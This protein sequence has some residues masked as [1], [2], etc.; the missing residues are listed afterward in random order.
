MEIATALQDRF[1]EPIDWQKSTEAQ[2]KMLR[3]AVAQEAVRAVG[4]HPEAKGWYDENIK[5]TVD[6]LK[7]LDPDIARPENDFIFKILLAATSDGNKVRPQFLQSWDE[8]TNWKNTGKISGQFVS[9]D[10]VSN[11]RK[12]L[13]K[14]EAMIQTVGWEKARDFL[15]KKGT[16]SEIREALVKEFGFTKQDAAK[17]G[18]SELADEV[19]PYAIVLG[20]KLGSFFNNL[21]GDFSSVTMDRWFMRTMGR[22]TGT[23]VDTSAFKKVRSLRAALRESISKMTPS[24]KEFLKISSDKIK[25]DNIDA[26]AKSISTRFSKKETR[27]RAAQLESEGRPFMEEV[28][29]RSNALKKI[30]SPLVEAPVN[31]RHRR[32]IRQRIAEVQSELKSRGIELE[33]AD[34][35]AV[36][37]YL[38]KELYDKLNYRAKPGDS[39]YAS[40]AA[41]LYERV[42]GRPSSVYAGS[43]GRIRAVGGGGPDVAVGAANPA[44]ARATVAEPRFMPSEE[45][46]SVVEGVISEANKLGFEI[47]NEHSSRFGSEYV[48]IRD[49]ES[50]REWKMRFSDHERQL[51][52]ITQHAA[53][54]FEQVGNLNLEAAIAW[55]RKKR[56]TIDNPPKVDQKKRE[57]WLHS[58]VLSEVRN[59]EQLIIEL[60]TYRDKRIAQGK[61]QKAANIQ[62]QIDGVKNSI[63]QIKN[64]I[65]YKSA[66]R[67][68]DQPRYML[69]LTPDAS[70]PGAYSMRGYRV[71]PGREKFKLRI[72]S[73][74]GSLLGIASSTD[75]AQRMIQRK[76]R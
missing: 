18:T 35:Q 37:W 36:L 41:H 25:G 3:N 28:R 14:V 72:Y 5:L 76:T 40:A 55:L 50:N 61:N 32:W 11:I 30:Q 47:A 66:V 19:V 16:V 45:V 49:P 15:T 26:A 53:P 73:P 67:Q 57:E 27:D 70:M 75:E 8:Y 51:S 39:D 44:E 7:E 46:Q 58:K 20:P 33:N 60:E 21:Y 68:A 63:D 31:G 24:E 65:G 34:L 56:E 6:V 10:R 9:G 29:K 71:L 22:L 43:A 23:Q 1:G 69:S 48:T 42:V 2:N 74:S 59:Y 38:E 52:S 13:L 62:S 64:S 12:N 54:N 4:L 17:V